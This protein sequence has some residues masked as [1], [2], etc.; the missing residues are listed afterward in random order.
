M[1]K[2]FT[3]LGGYLLND[4]ILDGWREG[5]DLGFFFSKFAEGAAVL[6]VEVPVATFGLTLGGHE[7]ISFSSESSVVRFHEEM[8]FSR[9]PCGELS[10]RNKELGARVRMDGDA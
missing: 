7:N 5:R 3:D 1:R 2:K 9:C 10:P 8:L 4:P 6:I